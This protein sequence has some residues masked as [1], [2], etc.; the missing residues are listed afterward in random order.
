MVLRASLLALALVFSTTGASAAGRLLEAQEVGKVRIDGQLSDWP[1]KMIALSDTLQGGAG[2]DR[3]SGQLAYDDKFLYVAFKVVDAKLVRT[4][5]AGNGEDHASLL[6]AIPSRSGSFTTHT[7]DLYPGD[8]GKLPGVV[9]IKGTSVAGSELVEAP[10]K[11]GYSFEAKIPWGALPQAV[12][13]RVGMRGALRFTDADSPGSVQAVLGTSKASAGAQLPPFQLEAEMGLDA[14]IVRQKGLP[15]NPAREAYGDVAGD[16]MLERVAVYGGHL[17]IVGP[18][19][20]GGKQFYFGELG[21]PDASMVTRLAL[22]DFDGDGKDDILIQKKLGESD[23]YRE[24]VQIMKVGSDDTPWA[25]FSHEISIV[26]PKGRVENEVKIVKRGKG[27]AVE[28]AQG[29]SEGFEPDTYA[30]PTSDDMGSAFLPWQTIKSRTFGWD[31]KSFTQVDEATQAGGKKVATKTSKKPKKSGPPV[32]PRPRPPT[33]DEMLDRLYALY[34]K[35]RKVGAKAPRF[36]FVTDVAGNT[37]TERVLV[38]DR[39][40]VVFGKGYRGGTT[41][42]FITIGVADAKDVLDV[43][44][45]DLTGDGKAEIIV[46][47]VLHAKASKEL[48]GD[49]V[50]RHAL[51]VYQVGEGAVKRVFAAETGRQLKQDKILGT[52]AFVP[53]D[54]GTRIELRPGRAVGWSEK[55]Y[56]FPADTT[57]AGG[58]EP[59]LLPW[60]SSPKKYGFDGSTF[61]AR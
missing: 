42:S 3:A 51:F 48:G 15:R 2:A 58:L 55:S 10:T 23:K 44:A 53:H 16:R 33:A 31:G 11:G 27:F 4:Q 8:P 1:G 32:P 43:T 50:D 17:T 36:D 52:V 59:L 37:E 61:A 7:I 29:K 57:A 13:T 5:G 25:A 14:S 6:V 54:K 28:I 19:Y 9:K 39:D 46:R 21:V 38:H 20:R 22:R 47:G 12:T 34:K 26:T 56:P 60:G 30:E 40:I 18:K 49:V 35:E 45:R 24:I 41:Y